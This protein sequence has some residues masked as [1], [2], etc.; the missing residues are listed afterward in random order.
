MPRTVG[1]KRAIA[2]KKIAVAKRGDAS[3]A[4]AMPK[5]LLS[6]AKTSVL[7][8]Q[9][10]ARKATADNLDCFVCKLCVTSDRSG[11]TSGCLRSIG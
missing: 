8:K 11:S 6:A 5:K 3:K 1:T 9:L 2:K 7:I 10:V 4:L